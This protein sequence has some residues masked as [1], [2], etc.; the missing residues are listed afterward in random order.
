MSVPVVQEP[1]GF[2]EGIKVLDLTRLL[3]GGYCTLLPVDMGAEVIKVED[4]WQGD[5]FRW[6]PPFSGQYGAYFNAV[7]SGIKK[8]SD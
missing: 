5:Y 1:S 3:P 7:N 2:L 8:R 6:M 4:P